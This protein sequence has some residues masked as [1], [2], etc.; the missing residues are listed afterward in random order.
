[1]LFPAVT[2]AALLVVAFLFAR[3]ARHAGFPV[4]AS[5]TLVGIAAGGMLPH[6]LQ[7]RLT[8]AV[9]GLFLPA[10][11]F[12][13][14]WDV[15]AA[16]LRRGAAAIAVLALPGALLT[17]LLIACAG[18]AGGLA[19]GSACALGAILAATDPV[20]VLA[21]FRALN[22][23]HDLLTIVEGESIAND[24]VALALLQAVLAGAAGG[25]AA[26][27][28]GLALHALAVAAGGI[29]AGL[30]VAALIA[31]IVRRTRGR[32]I[33]VALTLATAY[34]SYALA[35]AAGGSGIFACAAAGIA[36]AAWTQGRAERRR[37]EVFWDRTALAANAIV[38]LLVGLSLR[39]ER[40]FNEPLL[41]GATIAAVVLARL[42]LAYGL[43]P[44]AR[45]RATEDMRRAI[46][47]AGIRGGL[48]LALALGLPADFP[49][50][51]QVIDAVFAV[52]FVTVVVQGWTLEPLLRRL[53]FA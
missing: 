43:V 38:F 50:R 46:A 11:I 49:S 5:I 44:L 52:V 24:G 28:A 36:L 22:V 12:E 33:H 9:L 40:I 41:V 48:S 7:I 6:E 13:A 26:S 3:V 39:L 45:V 14:A 17:G 31:P 42:A 51:P 27:P 20:A 2:F 25:A 53:R 21:L 8:P 34:G 30:A 47:L 10:L 29:A 23:P 35:S 1:M 15:D 16:A 4:P 32:I 37:V 19:L 18:L